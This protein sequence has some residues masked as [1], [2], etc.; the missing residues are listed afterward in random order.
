MRVDSKIEPIDELDIPENN[1]SAKLF[2][3]LLNFQTCK[4]NAFFFSFFFF[5]LT[6]MEALF[7]F[8]TCSV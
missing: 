8:I 3:R 6:T 2:R 5:S 4:E 1:I 7:I